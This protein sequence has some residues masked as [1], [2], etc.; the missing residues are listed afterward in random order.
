MCGMAGRS[1]S[2]GTVIDTPAGRHGSLAPVDFELP[3]GIDVDDAHSFKGNV[4]SLNSGAAAPLDMAMAAIGMQVRDRAAFGRQG[5]LKSSSFGSCRN[6]RAASSAA[7]VLERPQ[8]IRDDAVVVVIAFIAA[9]LTQAVA[10]FV[11]SVHS[12]AREAV[13]CSTI[14]SPTLIVSFLSALFH[15]AARRRLLVVP[16]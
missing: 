9:M 15:Q 3:C 5:S 12:A 11:A 8:L 10:A 14:L 1:C 7:D 2:C 13:V 6:R 16:G 4:A